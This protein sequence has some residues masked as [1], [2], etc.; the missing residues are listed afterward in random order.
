MSDHRDTG[1]PGPPDPIL[2]AF[3]RLEERVD[4]LILLAGKCFET[5]QRV[6]PLEAR[7]ARLERA[8]ADTDP[9]PYGANG[10]A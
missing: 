6:P 4:T 3:L 5:L 2:G 7:V 8:Q 9:A 1:P 10:G